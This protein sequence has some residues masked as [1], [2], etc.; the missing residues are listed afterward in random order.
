MSII[1]E[2]EGGADDEYI[3]YAVCGL[4]DRWLISSIV[5][6]WT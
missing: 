4:Q 6:A 3:D 5:L 2:G 1:C